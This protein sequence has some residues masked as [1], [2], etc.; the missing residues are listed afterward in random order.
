[1]AQSLPPPVLDVRNLIK[2]KGDP[3]SASFTLVV[4]RMQVTEG[5]LVAVVGESGCGKTTLLD[6]LSMIASPD[7]CDQLLI[8]PEKN[9][10]AQNI[11]ALLTAGYE[12]ILARCRAHVGYVLQTGGLLPFLTVGENAA[13]PSRILGRAI[14]Q[15][16][17]ALLS[18]RLGIGDKLELL[19][20]HLSGGQRQRAAI[21]RSLVHQPSLVLADEP[22]AAVDWTRA[23]K[24]IDDIERLVRDEGISA[25]IVTHDLRL[26]EERADQ[27]FNFRLTVD[28]SGNHVTSTC[29]QSKPAVSIKSSEPHPSGAADLEALH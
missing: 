18:E 15:T 16:R 24:I 23:Q 10:G 12:T 13:L 11:M 3:E 21:L 20:K 6:I 26:V 8:T 22:T 9:A 29:Y 2:V 4:P 14:S 7:E 25:V 1:M 5:Q 17:I 19:P 28:A 27:I